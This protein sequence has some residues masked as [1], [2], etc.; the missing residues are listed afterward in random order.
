MS[1]T[2]TCSS[3]S[4]LWGGKK[5]NMKRA[6][7]TEKEIEIEP[8]KKREKKKEKKDICTIVFMSGRLERSLLIDTQFLC[9]LKTRGAAKCELGHQTQRHKTVRTGSFSWRHPCGEDAAGGGG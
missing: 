7:F 9:G 4:M 6:N 1:D 5:R 2:R 8:Y 3:E